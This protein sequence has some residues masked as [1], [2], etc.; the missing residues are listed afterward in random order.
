MK[1]IRKMLLIGT[2]LAATA[3]AFPAMQASAQPVVNV[4]IGTAPPPPRYERVPPPRR[5]YV[6]APGYWAWSGHRYVWSAGHWERARPGMRYHQAG[7]AQ[8]PGGWRFHP[9]GWGR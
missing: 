6:W 7:W 8:G 9:G 3:L 2:A 1:S 4:A 5:G